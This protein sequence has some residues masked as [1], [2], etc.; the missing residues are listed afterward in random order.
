MGRNTGLG[1]V[2]VL[3]GRAKVLRGVEAGLAKGPQSLLRVARAL[4]RGWLIRRAN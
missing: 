1:L 3:K 4:R 2:R